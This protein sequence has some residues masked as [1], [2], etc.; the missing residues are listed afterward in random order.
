MVS[1]WQKGVLVKKPNANEF[2][3]TI[4]SMLWSREVLST[5][6]VTGK[7]S[8]AHKDADTKPPLDA[9]KVESIC[10]ELTLL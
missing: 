4:M 6:S 1:K 10:G 9:T 2:V 8:N 5:H 3:Y 7:K